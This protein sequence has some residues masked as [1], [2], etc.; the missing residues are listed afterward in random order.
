MEY[1]RDKHGL[2]EESLKERGSS[3]ME[4]ILKQIE[5]SADE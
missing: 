2:D 4:E 3:D 1:I 5:E